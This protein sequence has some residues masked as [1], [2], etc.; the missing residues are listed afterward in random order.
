[1]VASTRC[2]PVSV[3]GRT[4]ELAPR[5]RYKAFC[6]FF[7]HVTVHSN[8]FHGLTGGVG[9]AVEIA[10]RLLRGSAELTTSVSD[11]AFGK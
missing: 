9:D 10:G 7:L 11:L 3:G 1:M 8:R 2:E 4:E 6:G 5:L